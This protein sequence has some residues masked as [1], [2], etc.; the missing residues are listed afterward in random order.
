MRSLLTFRAVNFQVLGIPAYFFC[1]L[2]GFALTTCVYIMFISEKK[3]DI[4]QSTKIFFISIIGMILGAKVFGFLTGI[5]RSIGLGK[6]VTV[7]SLLDTGIVYYGGLLGYI[8]SYMLC[9]KS[10]RCTLDKKVLNIVAVCI[11]L[12]HSIAR[13]GCFLSGCCFGKICKNIFA[14]KYTTII[15]GRIDENNRDPVQII[16][17]LFEVSIF[18]YLV[19]ILKGKEWRRKALLFRYLFIYSLG[20]FGIE[21]LRGDGRRGIICGISFGQCISV[22]IWVVLIG[23][24]VSKHVNKRQED[25]NGKN[26]SVYV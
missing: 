14:I 3:F 16:E 13:V 4:S 22:L 15:E 24:Y 1:A 19:T 26:S 12:F 10:K 21:F 23:Y 8:L 2:T 7:D 18:I 9:L 20:R 17:A 25:C 6:A 11:P 5:Y